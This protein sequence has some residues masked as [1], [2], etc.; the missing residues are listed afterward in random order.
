MMTQ[1]IRDMMRRD[2]HFRERMQDLGYVE[3]PIVAV[4]DW[5]NESVIY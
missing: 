4:F 2:V 1:T 3:R 5:M